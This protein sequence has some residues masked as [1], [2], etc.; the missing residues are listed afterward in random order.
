[1]TKF[2]VGVFDAK[3]VA[4]SDV[5]VVDSKAW[6]LRAFTDEV[7]K[8]GSPFFAH[9]EDYSLWCLAVLDNDTGE[10]TGITRELIAR[11]GDLVV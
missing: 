6:G 7:R 1:M 9:P 10:V 11:A 5:F 3:L 4:Y 2:I 8:A